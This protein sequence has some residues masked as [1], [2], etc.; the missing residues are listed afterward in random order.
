MTREL[1]V[2]LNSMQK[3]HAGHDYNDPSFK[4]LDQWNAFRKEQKK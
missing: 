1:R 4:A 2:Y 3:S